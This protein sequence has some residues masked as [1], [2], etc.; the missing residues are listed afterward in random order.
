MLR[1]R[2]GEEACRK[3]GESRSNLV[4]AYKEGSLGIVY[5]W[6]LRKETGTDRGGEGL[7]HGMLSKE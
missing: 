3:R 5:L 1:C 7:C 6:F 2:T 4:L